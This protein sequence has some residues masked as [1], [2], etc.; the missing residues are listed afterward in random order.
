MEYKPVMQKSQKR[1]QNYR[2]RKDLEVCIA[3]FIRKIKSEDPSDLQ[4]L[5][6]RLEELFKCIE[7]Y[8]LLNNNKGETYETIHNKGC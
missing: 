8:T 3:Y 2:H 6:K 1:Q 5:Q 4:L 7:E